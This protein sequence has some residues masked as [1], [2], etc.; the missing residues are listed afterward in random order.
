MAARTVLD[1]VRLHA[2]MSALARWRL[3][4]S[5]AATFER[6][7]D[8]APERRREKRRG[9]RLNWGK[10][11]DPSGR[12]LCDCR[13]VN[14]TRDGLRLRLARKVALPAHFHFFDD[15]DGALFAARICW[16]R[17]DEVGCRLSPSPLRDMA[18]VAQRMQ[19]RYYAL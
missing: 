11:L 18:G 4:Q 6:L 15:V 17:G 16:R 5:A 7:S 2:G 1:G 8:A 12:F 3:G 9:A 14:R 13:V 10:A 19:S